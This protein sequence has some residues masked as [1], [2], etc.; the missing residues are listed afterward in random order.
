MA[1]LLL[2]R[3]KVPLAVMYSTEAAGG[4]TSPAGTLL[5]T[6]D[7]VLIWSL[8]ANTI[9]APPL[10]APGTVCARRIFTARTLPEASPA[11]AATSLT[12]VGRFTLKDPEADPT[13]SPNPWMPRIF[14]SVAPGMAVA[15]TLPV[16]IPLAGWAKHDTV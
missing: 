9:W 11:T 13:W 7:C 15:F 3:I 14:T 5:I 6:S 12:P 4:F 10:I 16:A 1:E 2:S 8:D